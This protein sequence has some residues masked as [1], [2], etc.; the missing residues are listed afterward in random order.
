[1]NDQ[2]TVVAKTIEEAKEFY[3]EDLGY[4]SLKQAEE[5]GEGG[6]VFDDPREL[7]PEEMKDKVWADEEGTSE[8]SFEDLLAQVIAEG[9]SFPCQLTGQAG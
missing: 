6:E 7:T 3:A 4:D 1:M 8:I 9:K 2:D 5:D